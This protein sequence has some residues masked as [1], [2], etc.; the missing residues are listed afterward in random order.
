MPAS[1]TTCAIV[2]ISVLRDWGCTQNELWR[3]W[4]CHYGALVAGMGNN[5]WTQQLDWAHADD[6]AAAPN[7][8]FVLPGSSAKHAAG[9]TATRLRS[10]PADSKEEDPVV[11]GTYV[12]AGNFTFLKVKDAGHLAPHDQPETTLAM[13]RRF[14]FGTWE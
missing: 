2:N 9:A 6:F 7:Q 4:S 11:V 5:A 10:D 8:T 13:V 3:W 14:L 12:S 1:T